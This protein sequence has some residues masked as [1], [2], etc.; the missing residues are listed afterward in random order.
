MS[1]RGAATGDG[2][3]V[4]PPRAALA[5]GVL[6]GP[7][8]L[9]FFDLSVEA[10]EPL[11]ELLV[12]VPAW[13]DVWLPVV[14]VADVVADWSPVL[15][16]LSIVTLERPRRSIVGLTVEL[17]P[18]SD[19]FWSVEEPA[20]DELCVLDEP[21]TDGVVVVPAAGAVAALVPAAGAV[22]ALAPDIGLVVVPTPLAAESG[23]Q[24]WCTGLLECS[25]ALPVVLSA[26]LPAFGWL[27]LLHSGF[28][29][30]V[31]VAVAVDCANAAGIAAIT[32]VA[33]RLRVSWFFMGYLLAVK[34]NRRAEI[35]AL[36]HGTGTTAP[37]C[38][39]AIDSGA[40]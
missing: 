1:L 38:A 11:V 17:E 12:V 32:A 13:L 7:R 10:A 6:R 33:S 24:S 15:V 37:R 19:V 9:P 34:E 40:G 39:G 25:P 16:V 28:A 35:D 29:C 21:V 31:S 18:V 22:A 26:C 36:A 3:P 27:R 14:V 4:V 8:Y 2:R 23:M 20:I 30:A 5:C